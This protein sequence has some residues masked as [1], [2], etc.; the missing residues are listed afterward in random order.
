MATKKLSYYEKLPLPPK[1]FKCPPLSMDETKQLLFMADSLCIDVVDYATINGGPLNWTLESDEN[2]LMTFKAEDMNAPPGTRT[3][4]WTTEL[5]GTLVE[6]MDMFHTDIVDP[7]EYREYCHKFHMDALDGVRLYCLESTPDHYVGVH[8]TVNEL[9][10]LIKNKDVCF[11]KN[12][13]WCFLEAHSQIELA[14]GRKGWVRALSS[15]ELNCCPDLK[16]ALGFIRANY[17][18]S[19]FLFTESVTRPG[20]LDV[21]QLQQIDFRGS[22][23]EMFASIEMAERKRDIRELDLKLRVYRLSQTPF[24]AEHEL[25]SREGRSKCNVCQAKFGLLMRKHR[26]RKCGEVVCANCSKVWDV[27]VA[28]IHSSMRVCSL[29]SCIGSVHRMSGVLRRGTSTYAP[30][31]TEVSTFDFDDTAS[32]ASSMSHSGARLRRRQRTPSTARSSSTGSGTGSGTSLYTPRPISLGSNAD[33]DE[34]SQYTESFLTIPDEPRY[35]KPKKTVELPPV[36]HEN[37][38]IKIDFSHLG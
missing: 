15:V 31:V 8:W 36:S 24:L 28:G 3:W 4:A 19:G 11:V 29:C 21:T 10:G 13:D 32:V 22:L 6:V 25:V 35:M 2:E 30:S 17:H 1:Y 14:D 20:Y 12:R 23:S 27:K 9:P 16:N 26:C 38:M 7:E 5:Q 18:R 33:D 37:D 34:F